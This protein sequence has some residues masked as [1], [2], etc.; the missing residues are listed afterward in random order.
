MKKKNLFALGLLTMMS[1]SLVGCKKENPVPIEEAVEAAE[2]ITEENVVVEEAPQTQ[3]AASI[4]SE[5]AL[6]APYILK[7]VYKVEEENDTIYYIFDD[8]TYGH[9]E[10]KTDRIGLPF[11]AV[12]EDGKV[13]FT[14]G[15][16]GEEEK[17]F[18]VTSRDE[19][20]VTGHFED[21]K[22]FTFEFL[23][24]AAPELFDSY[25]YNNI[26]NGI[27]EA[28]YDDANNWSVRYNPDKID[29][30]TENGATLFTYTGEEPGANTILASY[31]VDMTVEEKV[32]E[33]KK[34][35]GENASVSEGVFPG[36]ED[37]KG[38]WVTAGGDEGS[39]LYQTAILRE[40]MDG[41]LLFD[42]T[43]H[44]SG[45]EMMDIEISDNIANIIDSITF[46]NFE[47]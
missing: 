30:I 6:E 27:N 13:I 39:G 1:L 45:D 2:E 28:I 10:S 41:Y 7:G 47:E 46:E 31:N 34:S 26:E 14:F 32:E 44:M 3:E 33:L 17:V 8:S 5:N 23:D 4:I 29:I 22:E 38:Y 9:T 25:N 36:T 21:G 43:S 12:Q 19:R 18:T 40:Y 35:Y 16:E 11:D 24:D 20:N 15:G 37:V 42:I